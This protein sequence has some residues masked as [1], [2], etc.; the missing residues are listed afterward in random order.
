MVWV[1]FF[2][3]PPVVISL[4]IALHFLVHSELPFYLLAFC[5]TGLY[6]YFGLKMIYLTCPQCGK[7]FHVLGGFYN[8][9]T[10]KCAW[11]DHPKWE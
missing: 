11:C 1:V 3:G 10:R 8:P 5:W 6:A 9:F 4:A 2:S 7:R